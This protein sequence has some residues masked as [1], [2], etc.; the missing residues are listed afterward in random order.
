MKRDRA[1]Q[2]F[3][4][5]RAGFPRFKRKGSSESFRYPDAKQ[6]QIDQS[7]SR[8]KLPSR[9][10]AGRCYASRSD[11]AGASSCKSAGGIS[12]VYGGEDVNR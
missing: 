2:N 6:C 8:I 4:A 5:K 12:A 1:Y 7:N 10:G 11:S 3:F 9:L